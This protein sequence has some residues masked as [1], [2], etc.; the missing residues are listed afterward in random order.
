MEIVADMSMTINFN[1]KTPAKE[2]SLVFVIIRID[3]RTLRVSTQQN[4][5]T[6]SFDKKKQRCFTSKEKFSP[7]D[8]RH[9]EDVN[10][11]LDEIVAMAYRVY[12]SSI[13]ECDMLSSVH[14]VITELTE[15]NN[16]KKQILQMSL[17]GLQRGITRFLKRLMRNSFYMRIQHIGR[18]HWDVRLMTMRMHS[19][20]CM[21]GISLL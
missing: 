11:V 16:H 8:N 9:N 13:T 1:L 20:I 4:V 5:L 19:K 7:R 6:A 2:H 10:K 12:N 21:L 14:S 17:T 15:R 18:H 3:G